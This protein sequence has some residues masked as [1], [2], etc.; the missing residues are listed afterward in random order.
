MSNMLKQCVLSCCLALAL[1]AAQAAPVLS[2]QQGMHEWPVGGG[3][4]ILVTGTLQDTETYKRSMTFYF[5]SKPG[6]EWNHVPIIESKVDHTLTWFTISKGET[7]IAD[8]AVTPRGKDVQLLLAQ[9]RDSGTIAVT[10]YQFGE[11]GSDYPDGPAYMF[12]PVASKTIA[13]STGLSVEAALAR[14][15]AAAP[16]K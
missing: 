3:K 6:E 13:T 1:C 5:Q 8:G 10:R 4:L 15:A 7:T 2:T 14:E 16:K 11:A 12:K 9:K